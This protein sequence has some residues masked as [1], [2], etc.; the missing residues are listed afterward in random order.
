MAKRPVDPQVDVIRG[1]G[2]VYADLG[3]G[4]PSEELAKARLAM[5]L[6]DVIRDRGLTQTAAAKLMGIDQ[7]KVSHILRGRLGGF[8]TQRLMEFLTSLGRD[9]EIVVKM[10]PRSRKLGR[11]SV[12]TG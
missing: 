10:P 7:P 12:E 11:L 1:T 9:V 4:N 5:L 8:S 6:G 2:N 3:F